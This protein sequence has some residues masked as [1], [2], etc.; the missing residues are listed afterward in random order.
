ME[1]WLWVSGLK[2]VCSQVCGVR[3]ETKK[4]D[5]ALLGSHNR[6]VQFFI[7]SRTCKVGCDFWVLFARSWFE[8]FG[9]ET[10]RQMSSSHLLSVATLFGKHLLTLQ[11]PFVAFPRYLHYMGGGRDGEIERENGCQSELVPQEP[12]AGFSYD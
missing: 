6:V 8:S 3:Q 2:A 9:G 5:C 4:I 10:H 12:T 1:G 7:G 11:V